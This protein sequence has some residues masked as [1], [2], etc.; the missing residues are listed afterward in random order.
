MAIHD[1]SVFVSGDPPL[2]KI[3]EVRGRIRDEQDLPV[4]AGF[5]ACGADYL[6]TGDRELRQATPKGIN[7]RRDRKSTRLN[8]S[9]RCISYAVFCLKK[10]IQNTIEKRGERQH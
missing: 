5:E 10:K 4:L 8:S 2:E 3:R 7:T 9:H 6:V 1:R